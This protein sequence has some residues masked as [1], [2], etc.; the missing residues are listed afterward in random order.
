[1]SARG[2]ALPT[3]DSSGASA[4][5]AGMSVASGAMSVAT[6][7][8]VISRC[9]IFFP[10]Y[11]GVR[12]IIRPAMK[13]VSMTSKIMPYKPLPTPPKMISP[14]CMLSMTTKTDNGMSES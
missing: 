9:P 4:I 3:A 12:P 10:R 7:T 5:A 6:T 11:S 8:S 2:P 13:I 1:M 14:I